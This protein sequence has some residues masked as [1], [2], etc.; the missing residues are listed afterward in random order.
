MSDECIRRREQRPWSTMECS[1]PAAWTTNRS[2]LV[3]SRVRPFQEDR[4]IPV[5]PRT[6]H[7]N[8]GAIGCNQCIPHTLWMYMIIKVQSR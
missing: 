4:P 2:L 3:A 1:H 8:G 6:A 7:L 5:R